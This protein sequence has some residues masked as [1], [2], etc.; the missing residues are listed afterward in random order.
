MNETPVVALAR[1]GDPSP[2]AAFD[3]PCYRVPALAVTATG[4]VIA[5]WDVRLDWRDL[6]GDFDL[7][8]RTSDDN[9]LTWSATRVLRAHEP[10]RGFG[11]ASLTADPLSGRL[12]CWYTASTGHNYFTAR[13]GDGLQSWLA[14]SDDDGETWSH[15]EYTDAL[16]PAW[17]GGMFAASGNG[18]VL[19]QGASAGT[20]L[21]PFVLRE[22][23]EG[24]DFA[25]V[26]SSVDGGASWRLGPRV[27]PACDEGKVVELNDGRVLLHA[28]SRP[29]RKRAIATGPDFAFESPAPDLALIEPGCNGGLTSWAGRLACTL[30]D[31][32]RNRR[33]LVLRL[34]DDDG[35]S[36]GAPMLL[37]EGAAGYSV[38]TELADG[39]LG[40]VYESG[41]YAGITFR[42]IT[43]LVTV[44]AIVG[45]TDSARDRW[46]PRSLPTSNRKTPV[47]PAETL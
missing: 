11:D 6:P 47:G 29:L 17:A 41:D 24:L 4:R 40:I 38:I 42:R 20:L 1:S 10:E 8:Q 39:A 16:R 5:I 32:P 19:K 18:I 25:A 14:I 23:S 28:R 15:R 9:G 34:S 33:R 22:P 26:A 3:R 27:G 37:V 31:D 12:L 13:P 46:S 45:S 30:L 7:V 35:N 43:G 21:Q 36:W 2:G 44:Q